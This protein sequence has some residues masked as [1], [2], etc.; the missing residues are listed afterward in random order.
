MLARLL[1]QKILGEN[2]RGEPLSGVFE[3]FA[4]ATADYPTAAGVT[5]QVWKRLRGARIVVAAVGNENIASHGAAPQRP[6]INIAA[7]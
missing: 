2:F 3:K 1:F 4:F 6:V 7:L 5:H